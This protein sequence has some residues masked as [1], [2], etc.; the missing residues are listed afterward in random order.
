M[1]KSFDHLEEM[2]ENNSTESNSILAGGKRDLN[3]FLVKNNGAQNRIIEFKITAV[4]SIGRCN[5]L[6]SG[7]VKARV[8]NFQQSIGPRGRRGVARMKFKLISA[9]SGSCLIQGTRDNLSFPSARAT[10][11]KWK[12]PFLRYV[13]FFPE[14]Y[15]FVIFQFINIS[16]N[17]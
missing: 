8:S 6:L 14:V 1:N 10:F 16:D 11:Q 9:S 3:E 4:W 17:S 15:S 13:T 7:Q 5:K 12:L 2:E